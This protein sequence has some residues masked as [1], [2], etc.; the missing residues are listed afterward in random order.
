MN[1]IKL[2]FVIIL[3]ILIVLVLLAVYYDSDRLKIKNVTIN[4]NVKNYN[5]YIDQVIVNMVKDKN[6]IFL[7]KVIIEKNVSR[8]SED[9]KGVRVIMYPPDTVYIDV[10]HRKPVVKVF[11]GN[12][13][14][15]YD[16]DMNTVDKYDKE[17]FDELI[18]IV[19]KVSA[20]SG[21]LENIIST[22]SA[23]DA[24]IKMSKYFPDVFIVDKDGIYGFNSLYKINIYF[25]SRMN[26]EKLKK[27]FLSTKYIIQKKLPVRYIDARFENLIAN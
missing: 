3:S 26:S 24:S 13:Y 2:T 9:L 16:E 7:D 1:F 4:H 27:A 18:T 21:V 8:M 22:V 23:T 20:D 15:L 17:I 14:V 25:G 5:E 19:P 10:I 11:N 12:G 6:I